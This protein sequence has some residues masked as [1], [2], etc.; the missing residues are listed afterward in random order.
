MRRSRSAAPGRG[1]PRLRHRPRDLLRPGAPRIE[2]LRRLSAELDDRHPSDAV[3]GFGGWGPWV[4][5]GAWLRIESRR[6]DWIYRDL[7]KIGRIFEECRA[8]KVALH[9]QPGHPHGFHTH[10]YLGEVHHRRPLHD[11]TGVLRELKLLADPYLSS[12][13]HALVREHLWQAN[14]ALDTTASSAAHA[15]VFHTVGSCF[16]Y[17]ASLVQALYAVNE[18][19]LIDEKRALKGVEDLPLHPH[20]YNE[21]TSAVLSRPGEGA[22]ELRA[23]LKTLRALVDEVGD[24]CATSSGASGT[25][26]LPQAPRDSSS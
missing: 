7:D 13:K 3:T 21:R 15:D 19:Y 5:G 20:A 12:L 9:H 26:G 2:N 18:R 4:N 23:S 24:L 8:G 1:A 10:I 25:R 14:F 17:V 16:E 11:P 6:V 22:D